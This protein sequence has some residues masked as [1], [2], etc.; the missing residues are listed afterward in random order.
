VK[1]P[2]PG[3][4]L[5]LTVSFGVIAWM[6]WRWWPH[7]GLAFATEDAPLGWWQAALL[8][9]NASAAGA[10]AS[11]HAAAGSRRRAAIVWTLLALSMVFAALD[12]R[13]MAHETVQDWLEFD[14]GV[15]RRWAQCVILVYALGGVAL[16]WAVWTEGSATLRR[17][18]I[19]ALV[20]G[21]LALGWD[22]AFDTI[23]M[24]IIEEWLE[25]LAE[26]LLLAG[27]FS[28]LGSAA[29]PRR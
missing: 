21:G 15:P 22:L 6:G 12:E 17:W 1:R 29:S 16:L 27:L 5:T 4:L 18:T 2:A 8:V 13:F 20:A 14:L 26:T 3:A 25:A 7:W 24:Q 11:V 28:E 19:A 10:L 23:A 9:A